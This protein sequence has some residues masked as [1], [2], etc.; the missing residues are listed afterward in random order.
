MIDDFG[1]LQVFRKH[2]YMCSLYRYIPLRNNAKNIASIS[3]CQIPDAKVHSNSREPRAFGEASYVE[4]DGDS[5][6]P[7]TTYWKT[8]DVIFVY[9]TDFVQ[10]NDRN[11]LGPR[12]S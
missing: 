4:V 12:F 7:V 1:G 3:R 11:L 9:F 6:Y 8:K 5:W 10:N 2:I